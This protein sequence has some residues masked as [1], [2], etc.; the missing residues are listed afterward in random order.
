MKM[1][2]NRPILQVVNIRRT[3]PGV[4]ALN[5]VSLDL[6]PGEVHALVGENG[7]GKS[8]LIKIICGA[9]A[10]DSGELFFQGRSVRWPNPVAA[11]AQ[12]M[13]TV[14]QEPELFP[15]LSVAEN[16]ALATGAPA[17]RL[18]PGGLEPGEPPGPG[19]GSPDGGNDRR[20][21]ARFPTQRG[22]SP[23]DPGGGGHPAER[24]G[25]GAG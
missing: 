9:L 8:T 17:A 11:R 15:T 7:A 25:G 19:D 5:G 4:V 16:M 20:S 14:H 12:G 24:Q 1:N 23:D 3:F 13:V 10:P 2:D 18:R 6:L 22:P 21:P